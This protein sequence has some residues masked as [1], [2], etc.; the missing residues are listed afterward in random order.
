MSVQDLRTWGATR[1]EG[2]FLA[3]LP[4]THLPLTSGFV[5]VL[6]RATAEKISTHSVRAEKPYGQ[7]RMP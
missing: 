4:D 3:K 2:E 6:P 5:V 7:A 1:P